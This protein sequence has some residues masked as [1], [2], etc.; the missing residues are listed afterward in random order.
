[1]KTSAPQK[2]KRSFVEGSPAKDQQTPPSKKLK[3]LDIKHCVPTLT[4]SNK[5][6]FTF[7]HL[8]ALQVDEFFLVFLC[9]PDGT[10]SYFKIWEMLV[11]SNPTVALDDFHITGIFERCLPGDPHQFLPQF[12]GCEYSWK[13]IAFFR[14]TNET[15]DAFLSWITKKMT[16][17]CNESPDCKGSSNVVMYREDQQ[18]FL[19]PQ[20]VINYIR[21]RDTLLLLKKLYG[22]YTKAEIETD[23]EILIKFF[24]TT[25]RGHQ[26]LA[27]LTEDQWK[28]LET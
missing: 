9:K 28:H 17:Y 23:E 20:P 22:T 19:T 24:G 4:T 18:E 25:E 7:L 8:L 3:P 13:A 14:D 5:I 16:N 15:V 21:V 11:Q 27:P 2:T 12:P 10:A 1:M 6:Y 26:I